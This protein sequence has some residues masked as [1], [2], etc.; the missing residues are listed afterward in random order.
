MKNLLFICI[1]ILSASKCNDSDKLVKESPFKTGEVLSEAWESGKTK[2]GVNLFIPIEESNEIE[3]DS[4][5]FRGEI[6]KLEKVQKD[7]Y[8]VYIGRFKNASV[9]DKNIVMHSDPKKEAGNSPPQLKNKMPFELKENEA[10][11][12]FIEDGELK[13]YK[14]EDI[15]TSPT[16]KN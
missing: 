5:Y 12:S 14:I 3:L 16:V 9:F 6:V 13:Y 8:L 4:V 1:V 2:S 15:K 11:I 7:N 10:V